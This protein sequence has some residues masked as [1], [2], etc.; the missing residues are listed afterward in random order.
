MSSSFKKAPSGID[1]LDWK[2]PDDVRPSWLH[3]EEDMDIYDKMIQELPFSSGDYEPV[4]SFPY[5]KKPSLWY[6]IEHQLSIGSCQGHAV[7]GCLEV[8]YY[9]LTG[10]E[11]QFSRMYAYLRSQ[12]FDGITSDRGSTIS[13]GAKTVVEVGLPL[14]E[15]FPYPDRYSRNIPRIAHDT[16]GEHKAKQAVWL[17]TYDD[18]INFLD[19]GLGAINIGVRWGRGGHAVCIVET[20]EGGGVKV[21]NS[22]GTNW[23]ENGYFTWTA[24]QLKQKMS[25]S[26][27]RAVGITDMVDL[28]PRT[29]NWKDDGG[30]FGG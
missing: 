6:N 13:G 24:R 22:W 5:Y 27:T 9:Y 10:E 25:E 14:E 3:D 29:V 1:P 23:G 17:K 30:G 4:Q 11:I 21:A 19:A 7:G 20:I 15:V 2:V 28:T 18:I 16:A 26:Y 12:M 8:S